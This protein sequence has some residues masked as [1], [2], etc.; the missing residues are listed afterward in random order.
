MALTKKPY[1]NCKALGVDG[2]IMFFCSKRKAESYLRKGLAVKISDEP[3]VFQLNFQ[4]KGKGNPLTAPKENKCERCGTDEQLTRHHVVPY[5]LRKEL[6]AKYKD[7]RSDEVVPLCR[8]CHDMYENEADLLKDEFN[9]LIVKELDAVRDND[10]ALKAIRTLQNHSFFLDAA[11]IE[12]LKVD[13]K[14]YDP[15]MERNP[16]IILLTRLTP[17]ELIE[18]WKK[19]YAEWLDENC[20]I[21]SAFDEAR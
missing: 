16:I 19:H 1:D 17:E 20:I 14:E 11:R 10:R 6:E 13:A 3:Y 7:H 18:I 9:K 4:T 5:S 8:P 2:E 21:E 12:E 15:E